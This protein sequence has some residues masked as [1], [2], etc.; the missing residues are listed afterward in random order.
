M[1]NKLILFNLLI[2]LHTQIFTCNGVPVFESTSLGNKGMEVMV[3]RSC[4]GNKGLCLWE[5]V[6]ESEMEMDS[7]INKRVLLMQPKKYIS[8]QSLK[9]DFVPCTTPGAPYYNC[10]QVGNANPYHRGCEMISECRGK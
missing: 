1:E 2:L 7:E 10:H 3:K 9:K 8:Y 4:I 5:N 6:M